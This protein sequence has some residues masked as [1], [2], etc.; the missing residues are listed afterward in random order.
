[1][2]LAGA[3]LARAA[4]EPP[5][6]G[7]TRGLADMHIHSLYSDGT[8]RIADILDHVERHTTLDVVAITDHERI[9]SAVRA[10][11][12]HAAGGYSF[13]LVVGEEITTRR[14]HVLGLFLTE[15]VAALRPLAETLRAIHAQ[16]GIAIAAHP[17]APVPLSVGPRGLRA[18]RDDDTPGVHF[19]AIELFNP[20]TAGRTRHGARLALNARELGL[21]GVGNSDAH[22]LE[23]IGSGRTT[24]P[25][26]TAADYRA[27]IAAGDVLPDGDAHWSSIHNIDVYRRQL[28]AKARHLWHTLSPHDTEWR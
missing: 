23:S 14:G 16:G 13:D 24:F 22:V 3:S 18:V 4:G 28:G 7:G 21:P 2:A 17:L 5:R 10:A 25:G 1:M 8:A 9:D 26:S 11:E 15:R 19:D 12:I 6:G 20:S 27:A